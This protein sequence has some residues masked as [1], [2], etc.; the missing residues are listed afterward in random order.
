METL[1]FS[2]TLLTPQRHTKVPE[3]ASA[4]K[5]PLCSH[6]CWVWQKKNGELETVFDVYDSICRPRAQEIVRT[7]NETGHLYTMTHPECGDDM[8]KIMANI[9]QRFGWIWTHD[10][11]AD[12]SRAEEQFQGLRATRH[13]DE[14]TSGGINDVDY[15]NKSI[16]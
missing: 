14:L 8:A 2:E 16:S 12:L 4:L 6:T 1:Y 13:E 9:S 5:M 3:L 10:L 11:Q 7:S 15:V